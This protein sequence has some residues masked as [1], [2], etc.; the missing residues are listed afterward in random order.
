MGSLTPPI[1]ASSPASTNA[2]GRSYSHSASQ[3]YKAHLRPL[4][5]HSRPHI[6]S[7]ATQL[8]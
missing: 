4:R 7:R 5:D 8:I 3:V 2:W 6:Q 1:V